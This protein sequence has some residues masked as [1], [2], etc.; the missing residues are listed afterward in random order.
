[1]PPNREQIKISE[2]IIYIQLKA[3]IARNMI[4]NK[5]FYPI[6]EKIDKTLLDALDY[7]ETN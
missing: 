3:Y 7:I 4:D 5:G 2:N 6:W 1:M